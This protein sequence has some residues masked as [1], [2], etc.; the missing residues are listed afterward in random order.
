MG[1]R[2]DL[3]AEAR[4]LN[5]DIEGVTTLTR[6]KEVC[7]VTETVITTP[8]AAQRLGKKTGRYITVEMKGL[9][10]GDIDEEDASRIL[11]DELKELLRDG[12]VL[13]A[14]LGNRRMTPDALGPRTADNVLATRHITG[15]LREYA[16]IENAR[17]VSVFS[18]D[19]LGRTGIETCELLRAVVRETQ[20]QTVIAVDA[21]ASLSTERLGTTVQLSDTGI[22]PGSGVGNRRGEISSDSLGVPVIAVGVPTVVD[23]ATIAKDYSGGNFFAERGF[24]VTPKEIDLLIDSASRIVAG[25]INIALNPDLP[26]EDIMHALA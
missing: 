3:A 10:S 24:M 18:T 17:T 26:I 16:G 14:G 11:A 7:T 13:V 19:V 2:T 6:E 15:I 12:G 1:Y 22:S 21:L 20:P 9:K 5:G 23:A 25:G 4:E 8:E